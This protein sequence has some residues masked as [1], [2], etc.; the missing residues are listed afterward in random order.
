MTSAP[1]VA[2]R[3]AAAAVVVPGGRGVQVV[4][5]LCANAE[6]AGLVS[7]AA[8]EELRGIILAE[9]EAALPVD[10]VVL[11]LHGSMVAHGCMD[12][13]GDLLA[14]VRA[15]T[16]SAC[17][18]AAEFDSHCHLTPQRFEALDL[19]V[20][21]K[22]FSHVDFLERARELVSLVLRTL[23]G[24]VRPTMASFD[25]RMIE[26]YPTS[27][28]PMRG[29]V[30]RMMALE[31]HSLRS[32]MSEL[33]VDQPPGDPAVLSVSA[34]HGF[35]PADV[36]WVGSQLVVITDGDELRAAALAAALGAELFALRG[37]TR[38][39]YLSAAEGVAALEAAAQSRPPGRP[40]VIADTGDNPGGGLPGDS[41][42]LLRPLAEAARA[43]LLG[44]GVAVGSVCDPLAVGLCHAAG[45][46]AVLDLR[47]GAR[48]HDGG[49]PLDARVEVRRVAAEATQSFA[50]ATIRLGDAAVV[51]LLSDIGGTGPY[52]HP[53]D[54]VLTNH[55]TQAFEPNLFTNLGV[56]PVDYAVLMLKSSNHFFAGFAPL[57]AEVLYVQAGPFF[58]DPHEVGYTR[59]RHGGRL[60]PFVPDPHEDG[61]APVSWLAAG[62]KL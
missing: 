49:T 19:L 14:R 1:L 10:A 52:A 13:E 48:Y 21:Y 32:T 12:V 25:C 40:L 59:L 39:D 62:P 41:T 23:N 17:V 35:M 15:L 9:L 30:D 22:E 44:G 26:R 55:R 51:R 11:G 43:G 34:I 5:G 47:L 57:A 31:H 4:E 18:L 50:G 56:D 3:E 8:H 20:C 54:I 42:V 33:P 58:S 24:E 6:P 7:Q 45:A 38:P 16:G 60:W 27:R 36:E 53:V 37:Q 29:F 46:G 2:L 61:A 28:Q